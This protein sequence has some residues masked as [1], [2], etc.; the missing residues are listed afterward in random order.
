MLHQQ[1]FLALMPSLWR[2]L[3]WRRRLQFAG[4]FGLMLIS[5]MAEVI[6]L[7][8]VV[9][10]VGAL[11]NPERVFND[12]A[13]QQIIHFFK[14]D[15]PESLVAFITLSFCIAAILAG[16]LRLMLLYAITWFSFLVGADFSI[17]VY[18]RT[19][20]QPFSVHVS[21]NSSEII[22]GITGKVAMLIGSVLMPIL[23][24]MSSSIL[25]IGVLLMLAAIDPGVAAMAFL[26]FGSLYACS[27]V[28]SRRR[29]R[30]NSERVA[31]ESTRVIKALQE[32]LGGIRDVIIDGAQ[33]F[34][35]SIYKSA[36]LPLRVAQAQNTFIAA[37][38]RYIMEMIG[39]VLIAILAYILTHRAGGV[40]EG[41]PVLAALA[42][43]A[44]RLLPMLQQG[45][46]ALSTILGA[47]ASMR[48][49][50]ELLEQSLPDHAGRKPDRIVTFERH[51][52]L[53]NI[54]FRHSSQGRW[55]LRG[56]DLNVPKGAR[57]GFIGGTGAGKSTL[58]DVI[59]SLLMPC[60]GEL[61]IDDVGV[62]VHNYRGWQA[63]IA[64]VPQNIFL[65][66][67]TVEENIA[68]GLPY[69]QID[70]ERVQQVAR[71]AQIHQIVETWPEKYQTEVG[72][73][74]IRISGGERQRIGIARA[75]YKQAKVIIL[76]E[77]TSALDSHTERAVMRSIEA[78]DPDLTILMVAHR[79]STLQNC[80]LIVEIENGHISRAG[81]YDQIIERSLRV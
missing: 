65:C 75:L 9:P 67:G 38:P 47:E 37:S 22:N 14:V 44:Q 51:I 7:G 59:M 26:T 36:D 68:F 12:P 48:D 60:E 53:K 52:R 25:V 13:A 10:F 32:G 80:D 62:G 42:L 17:E 31:I 71:L 78:L 57:V 73:R 8:A 3:S 77:A 16:L 41:L 66:D 79:V 27:L 76:D 15:S 54:G 20:Y 29:L 6:S 63:N 74:G 72:E 5:S 28:L 18:R 55:V 33:E 40:S 49:G 21:R 24:L 1:K 64:H 50:L 70:H 30:S 43:G 46:N 23:T 19:L 35:C 69:D 39:M 61:I 4:L 58:M 45:Y 11:T 2:H 56:I 34:Y 81:S